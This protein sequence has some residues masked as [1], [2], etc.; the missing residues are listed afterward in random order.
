MEKKY[1]LEVYG[2][3]LK[4]P[5]L[6]SKRVEKKEYLYDRGVVEIWNPLVHARP[7]KLFLY[8]L[9]A[10]EVVGETGEIVRLRLEENSGI[11]LG[12]KS[13]KEISNAVKRLAGV[14]YSHRHDGGE[15]I[16]HVLEKAE[17]KASERKFYL[18]VPKVFY[19]L[20]QEEGLRLYIPF[21]LQ[22]ESRAEVGLFTFLSTRSATRENF[23]V[24]T[25]A[26]RAGFNTTRPIKALSY[27]LIA[28]LNSL[29]EIGFI[30]DF[31]RDKEYILIEHQPKE[32]LRIRAIELKRELD[33][34]FEELKA[35]ARENMRRYRQKKK[36]KTEEYNFPF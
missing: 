32:T 20:C 5:P 30:K 19:Q 16:F 11:Y 4:Y 33:E 31:V 15:L 24:L 18:D 22:F 2:L 3:V 14:V 1:S 9:W 8:C 17:Y 27:D 34:R 35:K 25:L 7:W 36:N 13:M 10:G 26:E 21:L 23:K 6:A 29:K 12:F 28:P